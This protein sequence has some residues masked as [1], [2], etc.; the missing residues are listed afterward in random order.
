MHTGAMLHIG[1]PNR[2]SC[3]TLVQVYVAVSHKRLAIKASVAFALAAM[4]SMGC[5]RTISELYITTQ[6]CESQSRVNL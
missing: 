6:M 2:A 5:A 4:T 1:Y 3:P